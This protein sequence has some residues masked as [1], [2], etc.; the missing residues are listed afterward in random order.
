[1]IAAHQNPVRKA[2]NIILT[3]QD[4]KKL[5]LKL[6][7]FMAP[8]AREKNLECR[9]PE[10]VFFNCPAA[11]PGHAPP[12]KSITTYVPKEILVRAS[13]CGGISDFLGILTH[14]GSKSRRLQ[15]FF[16]GA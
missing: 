10:S 7:N 2:W 14:T 8:V 3:S 5:L 4:D 12:A 6:Q 13:F 1:M 15:A 9:N 16:G 11:K